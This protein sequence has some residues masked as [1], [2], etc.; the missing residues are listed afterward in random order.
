MKVFLITSIGLLLLGC[1]NKSK[2]PSIESIEGIWYYIENDSIYGEVIFTKDHFWEYS[3]ESGVTHL[4]YFYKEDS[5]QFI[6]WNGDVYITAFLK[7]VTEDNFQLMRQGMNV[8]Y[9]RLNIPIDT[10]GLFSGDEK[11]LDSYVFDGLKDRKY[12]WQ[13]EHD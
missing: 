7:R 1:L 9:F 5:I 8:D 11:A 4:P 13:S 2:V 12:D 3:E 10:A 6:N